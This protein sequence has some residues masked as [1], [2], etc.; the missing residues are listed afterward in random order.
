MIQSPCFAHTTGGVFGFDVDYEAEG[1]CQADNLVK[2]IR[3]NINANDERFAL[4]A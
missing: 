2:R 1:A 3:E 4:A